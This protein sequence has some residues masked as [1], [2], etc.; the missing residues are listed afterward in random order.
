MKTIAREGTRRL[1]AGIGLLALIVGVSAGSARAAARATPES[2]IRTWPAPERA[3]AGAMLEKYGKPAQF[4]RKALVW[5]KNGIWKRTIVYRSGPHDREFLQQTIG[6]IVPDDKLA[7]L[8]RF[9]RSLEAS[10]TAGELT[11]ASDRE[12]TNILALNLAD[13]IV[14]GKKSVAEA[15][16]AFEKTARLAASGKSS[17]YTKRLRFDVDNSRYMTPTG[18]DQ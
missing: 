10:T 16:A 1:A 17:P 18:A 7:D 12:A 6:Y 14:A 5:V 3:A 15:R 2:I 11:F 4:D 8:K 9:N 13:E